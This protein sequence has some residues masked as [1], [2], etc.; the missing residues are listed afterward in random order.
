MRNLDEDP[1]SE[2]RKGRT[3]SVSDPFITS[4]VAAIS[5]TGF[6]VAETTR[7][8]NRLVCNARRW[9]ARGGLAQDR[10]ISRREAEHLWQQRF[11]GAGAQ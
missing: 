10:R 4:A 3:L 9:M 7:F 6:D 2:R 1:T 8:G 5:I 11:A